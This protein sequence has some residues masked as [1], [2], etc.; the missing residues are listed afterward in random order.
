MTS[1][2]LR[3]SANRR[4]RLTK[5]RLERLVPRL[6]KDA[7]IDCWI[8]VS[9]EY[10]EDPVAQS[11]LPATWMSSRRRTILLFLSGEA[12]FE[13]SAITRYEVD[14][15]FPA[16]W[17]PE[18]QPDQ[19]DAVRE[20]VVAANPATIAI[21]TSESFAH[22][23]GLTQTEF[24][25]LV[26]AL[27]SG[28]GDRIVSGEA[29]AVGWLQTRIPE[30]KPVFEEACRRAHQILRRALSPEAIKPGE[31]TTRD[32]EWWLRDEVQV[33][34]CPV[35]FHPSVSIQ[36]RGADLRGSFASVTRDVAIDRGDL[37]HIDFGIVWDHLC[38]DQQQQG[39]V[40][41][42]GETDIADG[43]DRAMQMANQVQD[44]LTSNFRSGSS[45]NEVLAVARQQASAAGLNP[46]IYTHPIGYHGHGAG[47]TIGLW[48]QQDGVPGSGDVALFEP[49]AW[50]IELMNRTVVPEWDNQEIG[51]MLEEDAWFEGEIVEF[52]DG[53][54]TEIWTI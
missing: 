38:T 45:G 5:L 36:R 30:E 29:L 14:G 23:D 24:G 50:S 54:Q 15:L 18:L 46:T 42:P 4:D 27:G 48:D 8:L 19:W 35:W 3:N 17:D 20:R 47:A 10:A 28:L 26:A 40:L 51:I 1:L 49:S 16:G 6:M 11:M 12:E 13:R 31:T 52:V 44:I 21:S 25:Q 2:D 37:V 43:L 32:L 34:G 41:L 22:A 39:Y 9:R 7:K 33:L 53:R